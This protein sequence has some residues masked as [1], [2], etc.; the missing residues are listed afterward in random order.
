MIKIFTDGSFNEKEKMGYV[1]YI[2][3]SKTNEITMLEGKKIK[4]KTSYE[5]EGMAIELALRKV[6]EM[7]LNDII[8][9]SDSKTHIEMIKKKSQKLK[10]KKIIDLVDGTKKMDFLWIERDKNEYVDALCHY[11]KK[12][13]NVS[14]KGGKYKYDDHAKIK[15]GKCELLQTTKQPVKK[16]EKKKMQS[17]MYFHY[18]WKLHE[19]HIDKISVSLE[20][21]KEKKVLNFSYFLAHPHINPSMHPW[22]GEFGLESEIRKRDIYLANQPYLFKIVYEDEQFLHQIKNKIKEHIGSQINFPIKKFKIKG[23]LVKDTIHESEK[24]EREKAVYHEFKKQ[25]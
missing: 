8:L 1:S 20:V 21:D 23:L 11:I 14:I 2:I 13:G 7:N 24:T 6:K 25:I 5:A 18:E 3:V 19:N 10:Y 4:V 15:N 9:H 17:K 16:T 12:N 22:E